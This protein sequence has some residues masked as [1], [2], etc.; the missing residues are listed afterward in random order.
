MSKQSD[1]QELALLRAS[2]ARKTLI[3]RNGLIMSEADALKCR[4]EYCAGCGKLK[5]KYRKVYLGEEFCGDCVDK[6]LAGK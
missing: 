3:M 2:R 4:E 6:W 1:R 5:A